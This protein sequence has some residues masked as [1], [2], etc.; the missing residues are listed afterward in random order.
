MTVAKPPSAVGKITTQ[1][2]WHLEKKFIHHQWIQVLEIGHVT[3]SVEN[4]TSGSG[5]LYSIIVWIN[6]YTHG[7]HPL[8]YIEV[9]N[10]VETLKPGNRGIRITKLVTYFYVNICS[11]RTLQL[12]KAAAPIMSDLAQ[13]SDCIVSQ[14]SR[15]SCEFSECPKPGFVTLSNGV[16]S[17]LACYWPQSSSAQPLTVTVTVTD[18]LLKHE[19]QKSSHPSPVVSRLLHRPVQSSPTL[20]WAQS[21]IL[22][23]CDLPA[24]WEGDVASKPTGALEVYDTTEC[25]EPECSYCGH[26]P[27]CT[28]IAR[29]KYTLHQSCHSL[30]GWHHSCTQTFHMLCSVP[31]QPRAGHSVVGAGA[32]FECLNKF[33]VTMTWSILHEVF[34]TFTVTSL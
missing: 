32:Y 26:R 6:A 11:T 29:E 1:T 3:T 18:C 14:V 17:E 22:S 31:Q 23:P 19:L 5:Y 21:L 28:N 16:T 12:E 27:A 34:Q 4:D 9:K 25:D 15:I 33:P 2:L 7:Y 24:G 10:T 20:Y 30:P 13:L 8:P